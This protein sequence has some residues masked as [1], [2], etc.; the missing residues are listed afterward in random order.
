LNLLLDVAGLPVLA[1]KEGGGVPLWRC[2]GFEGWR[3]E[4]D[5]LLLLVRVDGSMPSSGCCSLLLL[6]LLPLLPA[7]ALVG[8]ERLLM[9]GDR[10]MQGLPL[11][12]IFA[13]WQT[14]GWLL[15]SGLL[16]IWLALFKAL[17]KK[18]KVTL[19]SKKSK[20]TFE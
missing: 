10:R 15:C 6:S 7:A 12:R 8:A 1:V 5:L 19:L 2:F 20:A 13:L 11:A 3:V 17:P 9:G 16:S 18:R 4:G 14:T